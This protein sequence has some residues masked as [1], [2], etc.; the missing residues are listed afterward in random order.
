MLVHP[1]VMVVSQLPKFFGF[2]ARADG[3]VE[4]FVD[5]IE[6]VGDGLVSWRAAAIGAGCLAVLLTG[7]LISSKGYAVLVAVVAVS[8]A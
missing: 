8:W 2:S 6:G 4:T 7:D 1:V 3:T 5:A